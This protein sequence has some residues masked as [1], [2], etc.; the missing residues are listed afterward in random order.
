[1]NKIFLLKTLL[2]FAALF[3]IV[4]IANAQILTSSPYS[5]YGL[6]ELNLPTFA[7]QSA[8]GGSFI[9]YHHDTT[10]TPV[11]INIANPAG[12]SGLRFTTLE[13]GGQAQFTRISNNTTSLNKKNLNFS[14]G[15]LGFPLKRIGGAAFGIMPYTT[16]GYKIN[17]TA[18]ISNVGNINYEFRGEGGLNK[19]F[20]AT[21]LKPFRRQELK[22]YQSDL[23][24][25]LIKYGRVK[26][27]A[28][29]KI[30]KQLISELSIGL[31]GSYLFGNINQTTNLVYP[32]SITYFNSK[33]QRSIQVN[34]FIFTTGL[35]THFAIDSVNYHG[36][37]TLKQGHKRIL[38]EKIKIG[39]GAFA[40]IP[41]GIQA[42][43]TTVI[44]NY[45]LDGGGVEVAKDTIINSQN[46]KGTIML[47]LEVGF[48]LS[49]KK[50]ERLTVLF[51]AATTNWK[52]YKYFGESSSN[53]SNSVRVSAGLNYTPNRLAYNNY[54]K[55]VQ[56][57]IG[58]FYNTGYLNLKNTGIPSY[59]VTAGLGLPV[60]IGRSDDLAVVNI[61]A[62]YGKLGTLSNNLLQEEYVRIILGFTFNNRWFKRFKYD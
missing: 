15:S 44:Y 58:A 47:P 59:A 2:L 32:G 62:Q 40:G 37:D 27:Y 8:M 57:R 26:K 56:Y 46:V 51:D 55:R 10:T 12:L 53:F 6:G 43:Q 22:F 54:Y 34:D 28:R 35:Q 9:A 5:R 42:K 17:S 20:L 23:H 30:A 41:S 61:T 1:M 3:C 13:L 48:G 60:G 38:K 14:Y 31:S 18:E 25:T 52:G 33:R 7:T 36:K 29:I 50:G 45:S 39:F 11:F 4:N 21:G 24:D 16:V 49:L 19:A